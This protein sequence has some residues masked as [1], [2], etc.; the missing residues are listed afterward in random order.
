MQRNDIHAVEAGQQ[1]RRFPDLGCAGEKDQHVALGPGERGPGG[2][3][4]VCFSALPRQRREICR[5]HGM[6]PALDPHDRRRTVVTQQRRQTVGRDGGRGGE[7]PQIRSQSG[8]GIQQ[9]RQQQIRVE[10]PLMTFVQHDGID[11]GHLGIVL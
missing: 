4:D 9:Q 2:A 11:P 10:M 5:V 7:H 1:F 8:P 3:R 6:G